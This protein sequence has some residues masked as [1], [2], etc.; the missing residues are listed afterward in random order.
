[1][2]QQAHLPRFI[3]FGQTKPICN[4][5]NGRGMNRRC[6]I[7]TYWVN[8]TNGH[9]LVVVLGFSICHNMIVWIGMGLSKD[10][11]HHIPPSKIKYRIHRIYHLCGNLIKYIYEL[12]YFKYLEFFW[13]CSR[14]SIESTFGHILGTLIAFFMFLIML[15][16]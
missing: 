4:K 5:S 7:L 12:F 8:I 11:R 16:G 10:Q 3:S 1:M 13:S 2:S 14:I 9:I 6:W 15:R